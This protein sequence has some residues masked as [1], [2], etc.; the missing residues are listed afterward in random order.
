MPTLAQI[1]ATGPYLSL[2]ASQAHARLLDSVQGARV[3]FAAIVDQ[4][5]LDRNGSA[6][7][8]EAVQAAATTD[9]HAYHAPCLRALTV[10]R[11][12]QD[13]GLPG[14]DLRAGTT[15]REM[16]DAMVD[17]QG[18]AGPVPQATRDAIL[19]LG[20]GPRWR[21]EHGLPREPHLGDIE[22]ARAGA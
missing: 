16:L 11:T 5:G 4:L 7:V 2:T 17:E 3:S 18:D 19:A 13:Y 14:A 8:L 15:H 10:L 9:A 6:S 1:L 22:Q 12:G 21:V 20:M